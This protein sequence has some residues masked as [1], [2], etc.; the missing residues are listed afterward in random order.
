[1][2]EGNGIAINW[3]LQSSEPAIRLM[4]RRDILGQ[5]EPRGTDELLAGPI[6]TALLAGQQPDGSFGVNFPDSVVPRTRE[7]MRSL[8]P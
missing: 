2:D 8:H 7:C 6:V 5:H 1:M 4:A 3:L